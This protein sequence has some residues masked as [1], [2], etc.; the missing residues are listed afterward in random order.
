MKI[1]F[2]IVTTCA[3]A[4]AGVSGSTVASQAD[5]RRPALTI[6]EA[7]RVAQQHVET[8]HI[9]VSRHYIDSVKLDLNPR[10]DRGKRWIIIYELKDYAKGG[11]IFLHVYM[12]RSVE[13][14]FGE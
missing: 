11:Q 6:D 5:A 12:N 9:D 3:F 1:I 7:L 8:H 2:L 13:M 4:L 14:F 10:G